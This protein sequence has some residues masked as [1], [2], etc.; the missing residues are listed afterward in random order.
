[1]D[2]GNQE[3]LKEVRQEYYA[4]R[5][6]AGDCVLVAVFAGLPINSVCKQV[7][8]K[9]HQHRNLTTYLMK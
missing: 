3:S 6:C 1:M 9:F 4:V 8:L 2:V 7:P 5:V